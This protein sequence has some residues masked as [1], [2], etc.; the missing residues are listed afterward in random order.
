MSKFSKVQFKESEKSARENWQAFVTAYDSGHEDFITR[1]RRL[2]DLYLGGGTQWTEEDRGAM[3]FK[4]RPIYEFNHIQPAVHTALGIQLNSRV[5]ISLKPRG[6]GADEATADILSRLIMQVQDESEFHWM[7]SKIYE[8]GLIQRRGYYD[9]RMSIDNNI[10][11]EITI[12]TLDPLDVIP[13]PDAQSYDPRG[14]RYVIVQRWLTYD[15]LALLYGEK[16]AKKV[17][18]IAD[19]YAE[20][21]TWDNKASFGH[22]NKGDS[23]PGSADYYSYGWFE[24]D[25]FKVRR[26]FVIDRQYRRISKEDV[27]VSLV[28]DIYPLESLTDGQVKAICEGGGCITKRYVDR[29]RWC[30]SSG[31]VT[32]HDEWSPYKTFTVVP[33]FPIFRRGRTR[34]MVDNLESPQELENKALTSFIEILNSASNPIWKVP[35]GCL[36]G[37]TPSTL[38]RQGAKAGLVVEFDPSVGEPTREQPLAPPQAAVELINKAEFAIKTISGMSDALQGQPG[39]EVS[40]IAIKTKQYQGQLQMGRHLDNLAY[41]RRLAARKILE[42]IQQFYTTERLIRIYDPTTKEL[43]DEFTINQIGPDGAILNDVTIGKY[44]VIVSD[45]PTHASY[46]D[47]EYDKMMSMIEKGVPIPPEYLIDSSN[48]RKK[49]DIIKQIK[50]SGEPS[51]LEKAEMALKEAE[52]AVKQAQAVKAE[53]DSIAATVKAQYE[54]IQTAATIAEVPAVAPLADSILRSAGFEDKDAPPIIPGAEAAVAGAAN[55][56]PE[57]P[58]PAGVPGVNRNTSPM[59][60]PQPPSPGAGIGRGSETQTPEDNVPA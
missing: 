48:V 21:D 57:L 36:V 17:E 2:D 27:V 25:N 24:D 30:V 60:P 10:Y 52:A 32:I 39:S 42:L 41:T 56:G 38:A 35:Q 33:Y 4:D 28:G 49:Y 14:W 5:D 58:T 18:S 19:L 23:T 6:Y 16:I 3:R 1:A 9:F 46:M 50:S 40:G 7:E 54:A 43:Q 34:S 59:Y 47:A 13:D 20:E 8:D 53:A 37:M 51:P 55:P 22:E 12:D 26:Y 31:P 29:V 45:T 44:D 11:G 15:E